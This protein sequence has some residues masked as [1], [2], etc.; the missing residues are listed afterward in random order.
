MK[1][2]GKAS[3]MTVSP[4][5]LPEGPVPSWYPLAFL[6]IT[7]TSAKSALLSAGS[8]S[9]GAWACTCVCMF[10]GRKTMPKYSQS[11]VD[12][13]PIGTHAFGGNLYLQVQGPNSRSW[14]YRYSL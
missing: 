14:S 7:K 1:A 11:D 4:V 10:I 2:K 9:I 8:L 13:L 12:N 5:I 6:G 3:I